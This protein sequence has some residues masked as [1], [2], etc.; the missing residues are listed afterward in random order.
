MQRFNFLWYFNLLGFT[1]FTYQSYIDKAPGFQFIDSSEADF[2]SDC[3]ASD[4][5]MFEV[6]TLAPVTKQN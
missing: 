5:V 6:L 1:Y 2:T 4:V 3:I